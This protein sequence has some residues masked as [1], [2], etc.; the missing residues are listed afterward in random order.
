MISA[1]LVVGCNTTKSSQIATNS[2]PD[3]ASIKLAEAAT[4]ISQSLTDLKAIEKASTPPINN[5]RLPYPTSYDMGQLASVNWSG[6]IEPLLQRIA[7]LTDFQLR[8]IG[9]RPAT[10]VL[11]TIDA[12]NTPVGYIVRDANFQAG[13][14][15]S[16]NVYPGI[17]IIELRYGKA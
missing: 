14:K 10:P 12:R 15:A 2:G 9:R 16:I 8:V 11:V 6:P 4:S 7:T 5:K 13:T 3:E 1:L 17:H